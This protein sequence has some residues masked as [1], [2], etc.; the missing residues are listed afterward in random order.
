MISKLDRIPAKGEKPEI[1]VR[2]YC[3]NISILPKGAET[4]LYDCTFRVLE[5]GGKIISKL[6]IIKSS[7]EDAKPK[8][9]E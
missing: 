4:I 6:E 8:D 9:E 5:T 7:P 1:I 3:K 2:L